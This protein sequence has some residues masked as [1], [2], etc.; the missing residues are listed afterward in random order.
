MIIRDLLGN[1]HK[2]NLGAVSANSNRSARSSLHIKA[3]ELLKELYPTMQILEEIPVP[4]YPGKTVYLDFL[5]PTLS[6]IV[7]VNGQQHYQ[8]SSLFHKNETDFLKQKKRDND[9]ERWAET[10]GFT[11]VV[12]PYDDVNGWQNLLK[13]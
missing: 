11:L 5:L 4:I 13:G 7:E 8:Q 6:L 9:K 3:R 12:L 10:N 2:I 1:Q